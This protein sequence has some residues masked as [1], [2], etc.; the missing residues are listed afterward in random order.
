MD[1]S[2][3]NDCGSILNCNKITINKNKRIKWTQEEDELLLKL[4]QVNSK[5][6]WKTISSYFKHR[7]KKQ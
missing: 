7:T 1:N 4:V 5:R 6:C 3:T 2:H